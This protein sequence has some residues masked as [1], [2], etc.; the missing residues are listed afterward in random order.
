MQ[1]VKQVEGQLATH[2]YPFLLHLVDGLQG[3][4]DHRCVLLP[5]DLVEPSQQRLVPALLPA[6]SYL[7][8]RQLGQPQDGTSL[9]TGGEIVEAV[10]EGRQRVLGPPLEAEV[11]KGPK[12]EGPHVGVGVGK[13]LLKGVDG[14]PREGRVGGA[15]DA[16]VEVDEF[17]LDEVLGGGGQNQL[18]VDSGGVDARGGVADDFLDDFLA[19]ELL[20]GVRHDGLEVL[21]Q[22]VELVLAIP[23]EVDLLPCLLVSRLD[24]VAIEPEILRCEHFMLSNYHI[25]PTHYVFLRIRARMMFSKGQMASGIKE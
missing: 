17:L 10:V 14:H 13:V 4:A 8:H 15:V 23:V 2:G 16:E 20:L 19:V 5:Q 22:V 21:L 24:V 11:G 18:G 25:I 6:P 9:D 3:S 7:L 12:G 1:I